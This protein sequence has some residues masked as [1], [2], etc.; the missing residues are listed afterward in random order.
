M[1]GTA[2]VVLGVVSLFVSAVI[3]ALTL[4]QSRKHNDVTERQ[5]ETELIV[6]GQGSLIKALQDEMARATSEISTLRVDVAACHADKALLQ[7]E[8]IDLR[9]EVEMLR[10]G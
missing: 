6:S 10:A 2:A 3:G 8:V 7:V 1:T 9:R 4:G 5:D